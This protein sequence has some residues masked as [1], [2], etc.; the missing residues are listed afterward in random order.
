MAKNSVYIVIPGRFPGM[1][2]F[3]AANRASHGRR[4]LGN[5]MKQRDQD[6]IIRYLPEIKITQPVKIE[7]SFFEANRRRDLDNIAGYYHKI[8]QDALVRAGVLQGDGWD[9]I[10]GYSDSFYIDRDNPRIEIWIHLQA[11]KRKSKK[12]DLQNSKRE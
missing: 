1:N 9:Y 4:N 2:E 6:R 12:S 3:V 8:F 11:K 10:T 5:V 7:Y